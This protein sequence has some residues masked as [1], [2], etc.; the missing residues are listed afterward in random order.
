MV[1]VMGKKKMISEKKKELIRAALASGDNISKIAVEFDVS[2]QSV[3]KIRDE[4][5]DEL[6]TLR[7]KKKTE[8]IEEAWNIIN[9][10]MKH[11]QKPE[12]INKTNAQGAAVV[13]GT[14]WDKVNKEK[15]IKLKQDEI[16]LKRDELEQRIKE[17]TPSELDKEEKRLRLEKLRVETEK[18]KNA[19]VHTP[20]NIMIAPLDDEE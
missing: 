12:V 6:A 20:I 7:H 9:L 10:Y 8:Y 15:E 16:K 5:P 18:I 4:K 11:V 14:L 17:T 2:R 3:R 13:I 19:D 1:Y